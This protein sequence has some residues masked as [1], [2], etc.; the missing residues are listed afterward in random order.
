MGFVGGHIAE[1]VVLVVVL[2][3]ACWVVWQVIRRAHDR[4]HREQP[5]PRWS[6]CS[7]KQRPQQAEHL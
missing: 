6:S 5:P 2:A 4:L 3:L 7:Q 1:L